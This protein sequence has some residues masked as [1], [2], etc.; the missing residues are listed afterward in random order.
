MLAQDPYPSDY[1]YENKLPHATGLCL[2]SS[3]SIKG[4][5]QPSLEYFWEG[6]SKELEVNDKIRKEYYTH[7]LTFLAKQGVLLGNR[8]L[9]IE[10]DIINSHK[11]WWDFFWKYFLEE[12]LIKFSGISVLLIGKDAQKL[13][14]YVFNMTNPLYMLDHPSASAKS[15]QLWSTNNVFSKINKSLELNNGLKFKI[16]WKCK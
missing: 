1:K 5:M 10:K 2:D 6:I 16:N 7:D 3:N 13:K 12:V 9:T 15:G 11:G 4:K 8:S 14:S